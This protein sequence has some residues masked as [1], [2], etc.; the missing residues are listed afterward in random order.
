MKR[1]IRIRRGNAAIEF[2]LILPV[3]FMLLIGMFEMSWMF[4]QRASVIAATREGCRAAAVIPDETYQKTYAQ[5][6]IDENLFRYGIDCSATHNC[7]IPLPTID[8]TVSVPFQ[9]MR[10]EATVEFRPL[11]GLIPMPAEMYAV[12]EVYREGQ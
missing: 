11:T 3:F 1:S 10:C 5:T 2:A 7:E 8:P 12:N 9:T 4:F 6:K